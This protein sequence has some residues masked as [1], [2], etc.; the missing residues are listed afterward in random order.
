MTDET[1]AAFR[2]LARAHLRAAL[3]A[4]ERGD[5][6]QAGLDLCAGAVAL[7]EAGGLTELDT[8]PVAMI[9]ERRT[10]PRRITQT[11]TVTRRTLRQRRARKPQ[12][13]RTARG[14][15]VPLGGPRALH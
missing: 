3:D 10:T 9:Y 13:E 15:V 6:T 1:R 12:D 14:V 11:L 5:D 7:A 2:E 4:I 8:D